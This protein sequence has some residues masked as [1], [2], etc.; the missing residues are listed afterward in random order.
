MSSDSL[1]LFLHAVPFVV[2]LSLL[3]ELGV[4]CIAGA[5]LVML[6]WTV[7]EMLWALLLTR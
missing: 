2:Q 7:D 4:G 5:W 1:L 6:T 3:C